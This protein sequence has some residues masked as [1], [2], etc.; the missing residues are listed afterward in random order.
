MADL[1]DRKAVMESITVEY[2]R[3]GT[4]DGLRLA[5]IEK[6]VNSLPSVSPQQKVGR[7]IPVSE[8]LPK[9]GEYI[10]NVAK[11]Y[12]VQNKYGDILVA[13]YTH[14]EYWEQLY[15]LEPISDEIVA[16]MPLPDVY[17]EADI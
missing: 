13:R 3:K 2:N 14:E 16:W 5:W 12:L 1:I 15:Q 17:K 11:Y 4:G 10:R 8:R 7:W 9:A 6:A